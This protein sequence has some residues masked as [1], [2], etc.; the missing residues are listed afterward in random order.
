VDNA[1]PYS[2]T[3]LHVTKWLSH[4]DNQKFQVITQGGM[5]YIRPMHA[6]GTGLYI[7]PGI[8]GYHPMTIDSTV[9]QTPFKIERVGTNNY[10]TIRRSAKTS[11]GLA[12]DINNNFVVNYPINSS[13]PSH[14][15]LNM[16]GLHRGIIIFRIMTQE[17]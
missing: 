15:C 4:Q 16:S 10:Y 11:E 8:S 1:L 9:S 13:H 14:Q 5:S 12:I 6:L 3:T 17:K 2:G 7:A